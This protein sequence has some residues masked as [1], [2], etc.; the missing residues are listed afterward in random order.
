VFFNLKMIFDQVTNYYFWS[1]FIAWIVSCLIKIIIESKKQKKLNLLAGFKNGGMPSSHSALMGSVTF[2][3]FLNQ[4]FSPVFFLSLVISTLILR[5]AV[6]VRREVGLIGEAINKLL[7]KE[8]LEVIY[9]HT[10]SQVMAG[11]LIGII[12][13]SF[14]FYIFF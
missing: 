10:F 5:D 2:S 1:I 3:L 7:K 12:S 4:G 8:K 9:G 6:T 13:S 11:L 14:F